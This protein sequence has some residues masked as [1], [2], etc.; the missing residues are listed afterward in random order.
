[1]TR[2]KVVFAAFIAT[3]FVPA[4]SRAAAFFSPR[5]AEAAGRYA[6]SPSSNIAFAVDQ[7][8]GEGIKGKFDEFSGSFNLDVGD[9]THSVVNF[10]LRSNSVTTGERRVDAFLRSG[11][12]F[13]AVHFDTI[14]FRSEHVEQTGPDTARITG[15]L[16][17]KGR[18]YPETFDVKLTTWN[19]RMIGFSVSGQ[20]FRSHYEMDVGAPIYSNVVQFDM[21]IE[22]RRN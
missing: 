6:I 12:V 18:S 10:E 7:I 11:A 14:S 8:G 19:G 3:A 15:M 5:I 22:G 1:M 20:I 13:D 16:T 9:L 21:M 2:K 4:V 17:A